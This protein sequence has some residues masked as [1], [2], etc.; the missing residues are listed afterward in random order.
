M[1]TRNREL[2][3]IIDASGNITA[4]G[5]LTVSG[6]TTAVSS[7]NTTVSDPLIELNSGASSNSNDLGFVFERGSTGN[8]AALIWDESNDTFA[9][10]TTTATGSSTGNMSISAAGITLSTINGLTYPTSDGSAN[11]VLKTDGSGALS[12]TNP[13]VTSI[14]VENESGNGSTTAFTLSADP[15]TENNTQVY[16]DGVY[17]FKNTYTVSGTTLTFDTAPANGASIEI[18]AI[19]A[20]SLN[21]PADDTVST[22]KI[23]NNAVTADKIV[24]NAVGISEL[25]VSDGS[26][27]QVLTTNGSGTLSF[28]SKTASLTG[29]DDQSSSNDDQITITDTAVVI[30]EDSDDVDFRVE[31]NGQTHTLFVDGALDNIGIGYS[32]AHTATNKGLVI[33]TGDG[34]GGIQLNKE[35]GSYPSSGETLGSIGWKGADS[36]NSNAAAGASIVGIAAEDFSGSTEATNLAFNT[37]PSGTGPGS[38]PSERMRIDSSGKVGIGETSPDKQLHIKNTATGDTGIVIENTNNAQNLDIDFYNNV[39]SAQG[40]IRY[41][42]GAGSFSLEPNVSDNNAFNILYN[43]VVD[44]T[45]TMSQDIPNSTHTNLWLVDTNSVAAGIGGSI[46]FGGNYTGTT[47]LANGPY[48]KAY[49]TNATDGDYGF[50]LK[51]AVRKMSSSQLV[52]MELTSDADIVFPE[53]NIYLTGSNDRRIKLSDSGISGASDSNNTVHIRGDNDSMK[54]MAAGNGGFIFEENGTEHMRINSG[55]NVGI[56]DASPMSKVQIGNPPNNMTTSDW[57]RAD[58]AGLNLTIPNIV[59]LANQIIFSNAAAESYGYGAIGMVMTS[60]SGIGLADMKFA[61]KGTGSNAAST[62]R[63]TITSGGN[64]GAPTG[65]NIYNASDARLKQNINSLSGSLNIVNNLN[66]ISFNWADNFEDSEKDKTLYGFVAQEVQDVFPDAV[67]DFAGGVG[68]E[69]NGEIIENPLAVREKFIVP[70]LVKAIQEQQEQIETLK[71]EVEELKG[72]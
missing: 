44:I 39:G 3:S 27:G 2:A 59:T 66:P 10:G 60:G 72:G 57:G 14:A 35:D 64:I 65:T 4:S 12:F 34:N 16:I 46:V 49:K 26:N 31:S 32:A 30:N 52:A 36:A 53:G 67:E 70:L 37:K 69:L 68:I 50:G 21:N 51:L 28:T 45:G 42:E 38:A 62:E 71:Q 15:G 43:G 11:Q 5:N 20:G 9:L 23:Q 7:T 55:G 58:Y 54:L 13:T 25:N 22:A 1:T 48:I 41:A 33:L 24:A 29:V 18:I 6:T 8:N 19:T 47:S 56:N 61:T 17:Q 63:M 40:R